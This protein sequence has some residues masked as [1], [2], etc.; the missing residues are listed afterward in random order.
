MSVTR[1]VSQVEMAP[2]FSSAADSSAKYS[3]IAED[4]SLW[5]LNVPGEG[6]GDGGGEH[7]KLVHSEQKLLSAENAPLM[8]ALL[9][10]ESP[11][12]FR[13]ISHLCRTRAAR[14]AERAQWACEHA[15]RSSLL[16]VSNP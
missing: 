2:Y 16:R 12:A 7:C 6:G 3:E 4:S 5:E 8:R 14:K 1:L 13:N 9:Q 11:S 15:A 10:S